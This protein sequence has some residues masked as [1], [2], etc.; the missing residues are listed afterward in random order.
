[1]TRRER[2]KK[3]E[4]NKCDEKKKR[5]KKKVKRLAFFSL[6]ET[7]SQSVVRFGSIN[8]DGNMESV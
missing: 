5:E 8:L 2:E 1:M 7:I 4:K 6:N 3:G